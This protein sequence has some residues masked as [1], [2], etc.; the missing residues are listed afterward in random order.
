M[1]MAKI[2]YRLYDAFPTKAGAR[3]AAKDLRFAGDRATTKK[4]A[5]QAGGRLNWGVFVGGRRKIRL[6][7]R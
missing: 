7:N 5:P 1:K 3:S 2:R 6:K 4:I